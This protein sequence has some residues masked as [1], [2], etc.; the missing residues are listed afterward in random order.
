MHHFRATVVGDR[1][2]SAC[3]AL[4]HDEANL[5][6]APLRFAPQQPAVRLATGRDLLCPQVGAFPQQQPTIA[7]VADRAIRSDEPTSPQVDGTRES[8][9]RRGLVK[10]SWQPIITL[11]V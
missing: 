10:K 9:W 4:S 1:P 2:H 11:R 6:A 3:A 7:R 5:V 8:Q